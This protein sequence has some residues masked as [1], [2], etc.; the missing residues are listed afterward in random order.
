LLGAELNDSESEYSSYCFLLADLPGARLV[1]KAIPFSRG[2]ELRLCQTRHF[3][4]DF[5]L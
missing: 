5:S 1:P 3:S 2:K 4:H